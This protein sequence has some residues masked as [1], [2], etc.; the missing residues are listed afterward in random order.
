MTNRERMHKILDLEGLRIQPVNKT[1]IEIKKASSKKKPGC[2]KCV[3]D[4][5]VADGL[6]A[7]NFG[8]KEKGLVGFMIF[9]PTSEFDHMY[10][11]EKVKNK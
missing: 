10:E 7:E 5:S 2:I 11:E 1:L 4:D 9:V 8:E 3:V 6:M